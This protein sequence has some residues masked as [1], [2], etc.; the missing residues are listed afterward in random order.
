MVVVGSVGCH[1]ARFHG[2]LAQVLVC[3][4]GEHNLDWKV[5]NSAISIALGLFKSS[6]AYFRALSNLVAVWSRKPTKS[7]IGRVESLAFKMPSKAKLK[8]NSKR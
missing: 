2:V 3:T 8:F 1:Q 7:F 6:N 5:L 4:G